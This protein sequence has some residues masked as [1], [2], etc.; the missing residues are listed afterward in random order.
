M[1]VLFV[2][3]QLQSSLYNYAEYMGKIG[4]IVPF[5]THSAFYTKL[6]KNNITLSKTGISSFYMFHYSEDYNFDQMINSIMNNSENKQWHQAIEQC[7]YA[8]KNNM[9]ILSICTLLPVLEGILS[10]FEEDKTNIRMMKVC[11]EM[12]NTVENKLTIDPSYLEA[13]LNKALW[14]SCYHFIT[15]LYQKSDFSGAEPEMLNRHWILHGRT[16]FNNSQIDS[17]RVFNAIETV[18]SIVRKHIRL[19]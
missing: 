17:I 1:S 7:V 3:K 6:L 10:T 14:I 19:N 8:Y 4:W 16:A 5:P 11:K 9:Y 12:L 15:A 18:S 13:I 2:S